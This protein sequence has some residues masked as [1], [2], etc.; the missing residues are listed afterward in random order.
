MNK[1]IMLANDLNDIKFFYKD[2][3]KEFFYKI[4]LDLFF[5]QVIY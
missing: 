4:L 2:L 1:Y 3:K 5:K